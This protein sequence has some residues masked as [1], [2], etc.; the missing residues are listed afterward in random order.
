MFFNKAPALLA[1]APGIISAILL[2]IF[3]S[4]LDAQTIKEGQGIIQVTFESGF[5]ATVFA[6]FAASALTFIP[7]K[8]VESEAPPKP[9]A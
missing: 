6:A 3:K 4:R 5:W 7:E 9:E 8:R 2:L 1:G